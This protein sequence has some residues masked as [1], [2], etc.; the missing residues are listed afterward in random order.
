MSILSDLA[1]SKDVTQ[2]WRAWIAVRLLRESYLEEDRPFQSISAILSDLE[3]QIGRLK[4]E[5][6]KQNAKHHGFRLR[7]SRTNHS[8]VVH[9]GDFPRPMMKKR[10]D[11]RRLRA[12]LS[13][14]QPLQIPK[15][16]MPTSVSAFRF[17]RG[18]I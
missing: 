4:P 7:F 16:A 10:R 6:K 11:R 3:F 14:A 9:N 17:L 18:C 13:G 8:I 12:S 2:V 15:G 5:T 1:L